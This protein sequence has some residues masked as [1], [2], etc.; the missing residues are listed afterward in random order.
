M[1]IGDS[2]AM[3]AYG[4][5]HNGNPWDPIVKARVADRAE[6]GRDSRFILN[7]IVNKLCDR[8]RGQDII[9]FTGA[10]DIFPANG[11]HPEGTLQKDKIVKQIRTLLENGARSI[12]L[13]PIGP[14][15]KGYGGSQAANDQLNDIVRE[16]NDPRVGLN[17]AIGGQYYSD[18]IHLN[19]QGDRLVKS[20]A[21]EFAANVRG[22]A[23][24]SPDIQ[25]APFQPERDRAR[26][27][28][29]GT[30]DEHSRSATPRRH[31]VKDAA[32]ANSI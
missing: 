31:P 32:P 15:K 4:Y 20:N 5:Q 19:T 29:A 17:G 28:Q 8:V 26:L 3:N 7:H 25:S 6:G 30:Q 11:R 16:I 18:T 2:R 21:R 24:R 14:G 9:L 10:C 13:A 22:P 1:Y 12:F 23:Y 27:W